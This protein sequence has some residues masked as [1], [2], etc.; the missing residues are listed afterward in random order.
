M[1]VIAV[2][3]KTI[4]APFFTTSI[5]PVFLGASIA[6]SEGVAF[7]WGHFLLSMAIA[8]ACQAGSNLIN[9]YYDHLSS[10]DDINRNRSPFNGGSGSI[11][12]GIVKPQNVKK[13]AIFCYSL[14][15]ALG[16]LLFVPHNSWALLLV[17]AGVLSGVCYS[18]FPALSYMGL[19][20]LLVGL[21]FGPLLVASAY[22]AQAE[23]IS[24]SAIVISI[25][26]GLLVA[27]V[28][29]INQFPDFEADKAVNKKNIVV[30]L[31]LRRAL[32]Y[33]YLLLAGAYLVIVIGVRLGVIPSG[34]LIVMFTLPLALIAAYVA[35]KWYDNP[36]KILPA[37]A[38]TAAIQFSVGIL[39]TA[40]FVWPEV[41]PYFQL[42]FNW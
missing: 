11:Q 29:Y 28:L 9:D 35:A 14:C 6:L 40:S 38:C 36:H 33:Y 12:E 32:P 1:H 24:I 10:N 7:S 3:W 42:I 25:P 17:L 20:E 13:A 39:L 34:A 37:N 4:R 18:K 8:C 16:I 23:R 21:N 30:R 15:F 26:V 5:V 22:F 41:G 27:A 19:G 31:G 2:W